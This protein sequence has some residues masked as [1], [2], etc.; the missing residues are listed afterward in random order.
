[1]YPHGRLTVNLAPA[2]LRKEGPAYDLPTVGSALSCRRSAPRPQRP[3]PRR[4]R[5]R[6]PWSA[7]SPSTARCATPTASRRW[8]T[9]RRSWV[10]GRS[11]VPVADAPE[12]A[13]IQGSDVYPVETLARLVTH[14]RD[15]HPI[16][17][18]RAT[19]DVDAEPPPYGA[20]LQDTKGQI[21][22]Q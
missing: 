18:C 15:Y 1:M 13:L 9:W 20:D 11:L 3:A 5:R 17:P 19:L 21:S 2:D 6:T 7:S 12:A 16:E 14:F 4:P 22:G 10:N 8:P